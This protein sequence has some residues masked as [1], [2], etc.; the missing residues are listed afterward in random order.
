MMVEEGN[1]RDLA[2]V[3]ELLL[4]WSNLKSPEF[5]ELVSRFYRELCD[6]LFSTAS[7]D[8]AADEEEEHATALSYESDV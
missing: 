5:V 8:A 2:D 4:C 6:E 1:V 7:G 3:E